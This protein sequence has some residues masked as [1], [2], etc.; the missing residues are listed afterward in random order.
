MGCDALILDY[1]R[2]GFIDWAAYGKLLAKEDQTHALSRL[3]VKLQ[4]VWGL[5]WENFS[6]DQETFCR[7]M[8]EFIAKNGKKMSLAEISQAVGVLREFSNS[9]DEAEALLNA[10]VD[11]YVRVA[12]EDALS[13]LHHGGISKVAVDTHSSKIVQRNLP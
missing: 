4:I 10:R 9:G 11:A 3:G 6:V 2:L 13:Q 1:L 7:E 8:N 12:G 5:L